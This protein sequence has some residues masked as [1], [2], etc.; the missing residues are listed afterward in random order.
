MTSDRPPAV[1][2]FLLSPW[3][4]A[5]D[6]YYGNDAE[7]YAAEPEWA[8]PPGHAVGDAMVVV[9][10]GRELGI[11]NVEVLAPSNTADPED[12][13]TEDSAGAHIGGLSVRAIERRMGERM[14]SAPATLEPAYARRLLA[15]I[16]AEEADPTPWR[17]L[18]ATG[19]GAGGHE[20]NPMVD[21]V[22]WEWCLCCGAAASLEPH[23][24]GPEDVEEIPF[25]R[26]RAMAPVCREC[27]DK[28]H[29][30]LGPT[31]LQLIFHNRPA[32]PGCGRHQAMAVLMG[33]PPGPP[34]PGTILGGCVLGE[35]PAPRYR[36]GRCGSAWSD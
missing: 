32:C 1:H 35:E 27:H 33:M 24:C 2:L 8:T 5:V 18:D 36:C 4:D 16:G 17:E 20:A 31:V 19:C 22:D 29:R 25:A 34:A 10:P 30:P 28:L 7:C 23:L 13:A 9:V 15:A 6:C 12:W 21:G 11:L 26:D 3:R 14:P